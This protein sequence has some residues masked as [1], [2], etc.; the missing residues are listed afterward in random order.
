MHTL[1]T[2]CVYVFFGP[3][4]AG[5]VLL[6]IL[7]GGVPPG[8]SNPDRQKLYYHYVDY[9]ANKKKYSNSFWIRIFLFLSLL[10]LNGND[11]YVHTLRSFLENHT[12]FQAK[13]AKC[14]P[15]FR[16]TWAKCI[17]VFR[18]KRRKNPTRWGR[19]YLDG[20]YNGVPPGSLVL[21]FVSMLRYAFDVDAIVCLPR[22]WLIKEQERR[23]L[24]FLA[25]AWQ[26]NSSAVLNIYKSI[27]HSIIHTYDVNR[28]DI[29]CISEGSLP[30]I[31]FYTVH[32]PTHVHSETIIAP[33]ISFG[34]N[35]IS[36]NHN[37]FLFSPPC[38]LLS[39]FAENLFA[40]S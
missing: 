13:W 5:G 30:K 25:L 22:L 19:T 40:L 34:V 8:S 37:P 38:S 31:N 33:G 21:F 28:L 20:L 32:F 35:S 23:S 29:S 15:V 10:I 18:S 11:K 39:K 26:G 14:I 36:L 27:S 17:P 1:I 6:E 7:G 2:R 3:G 24:Q 12:R 9:S 4:E 16:S